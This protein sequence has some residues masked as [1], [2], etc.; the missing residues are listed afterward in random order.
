MGRPGLKRCH[1]AWVRPNVS[2]GNSSNRP[3]HHAADQATYLHVAS[4]FTHISSSL[5]LALVVKGDDTLSI[6]GNWIFCPNPIIF[7]IF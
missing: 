6:P 7:P 1:N 2:V 3:E 4:Q 5:A